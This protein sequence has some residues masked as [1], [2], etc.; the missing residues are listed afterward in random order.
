MASLSPLPGPD[1][2]SGAI[3]HCGTCELSSSLSPFIFLL[4][5]P[6]LFFLYSST[7]CLQDS[8]D[9]WPNAFSQPGSFCDALSHLCPHLFPICFMLVP[10]FLRHSTPRVSDLFVHEELV[11]PC[12]LIPAQVPFPHRDLPWPPL[13]FLLRACHSWNQSSDCL[14]LHCP[15]LLIPVGL[16]G[17]LQP[18]YLF[19]SLSFMFWTKGASGKEI[20]LKGELGVWEVRSFVIFLSINPLNP[21]HEVSCYKLDFAAVAK[22]WGTAFLQLDS[23]PNTS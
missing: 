23:S 14:L 10:Y 15:P 11:S 6:K 17:P 8:P 12:P 20:H 3:W 13:F 18:F 19:F 1:T 16:W 7:F 22:F 21:Y 2:P 5:L 9:C 4:S